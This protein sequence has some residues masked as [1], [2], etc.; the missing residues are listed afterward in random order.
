MLAAL[1][2]D[3]KLEKLKQQLKDVKDGIRQ[4]RKTAKGLEKLIKVTR[5]I[6]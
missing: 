6:D 2:D 1:P 3:V 4:E 5:V